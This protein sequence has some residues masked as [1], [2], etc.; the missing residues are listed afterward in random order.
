MGEA[1]ISRSE[2]LALALPWLVNLGLVAWLAEGIPWWD[3]WEGI[4]WWLSVRDG[5]L[6]VGSSWAPHNEHRVVLQ[7]VLFYLARESGAG[8]KPVMLLS[9]ALLGATLWQ[10]APLLR[11]AVVGLPTRQRAWML[12]AFGAFVLSWVQWLNVLMAFQVSWAG[13]L[14]GPVMA[15]RGQVLVAVFQARGKPTEILSLGLADGAERWRRALYGA[16]RDA[17][18]PRGLGLDGSLAVVRLASGL[19]LIDAQTGKSIAAA[20]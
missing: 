11:G 17:G 9:Q 1:Q 2:R 19:M 16:G 14:L 13:A 6:N 12:V 15:V 20:P 8:L 7:R 10:L 4:D 3:D 18:L 5:S